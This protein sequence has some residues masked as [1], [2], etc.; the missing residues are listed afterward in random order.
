MAKRPTQLSHAAV[1]RAL[2]QSMLGR[3]PDSEGGQSKIDALIDGSL[4]LTEIIASILHSDE[5][6]EVN[7][8]G[9]TG[10]RLTNDQTQFGEF[11][12]LLKLWINRFA[13]HRIVVDVGAR[14][15]ARSNSY[16]LMKSFGW[17]G[18]LFEA[19]P[20]LI[21]S[22]RSE[23]HGLDVQIIPCAVSDYTGEAT[24]HLGVN[25][26]VSS[27]NA[28]A[29]AGWGPL[30][31]AVTVPVER[32]GNILRDYG[33]PQDFDLLSIDIEGED[34]KVLNDVVVAF[35]YRPR[36]II[37]EAS[38]DFATTSLDD[39]PADDLVR[40]TYRIVGQTS[41]NLILGLIEENPID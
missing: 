10:A 28:E 39:L 18:Y 12:I 2:Y 5:F 37:I 17:R 25:D 26:D 6:A 34:V 38:Y 20:R 8:T 7:G 29:A 4:N 19:N 41:A 33:V 15:K 27:L 11:E 1:V 32:L 3:E 36:W 13:N 22:I 35:G 24:F 16:D 21:E 40:Q 31:G 14:G 9:D 30:A 23:F